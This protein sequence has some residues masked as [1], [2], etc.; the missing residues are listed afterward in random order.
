MVADFPKELLVK[1]LKFDFLVP[2]VI[3]MSFHW[4]DSEFGVTHFSNG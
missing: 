1:A 3:F 2:F 4:D